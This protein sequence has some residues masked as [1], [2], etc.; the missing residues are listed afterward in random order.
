VD[1]NSLLKN[2]AAIY[3]IWAVTF[4]FTSLAMNLITTACFWLNISYWTFSKLT[5]LAAV[6][7]E[8][9]MFFTC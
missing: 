7:G 2:M 6:A 9:L 8:A 4:K 3:M 5:L 1:L